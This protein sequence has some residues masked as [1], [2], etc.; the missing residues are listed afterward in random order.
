MDNLWERIPA[1]LRIKQQLIDDIKSGQRAVHSKLPPEEEMCRTFQV[2]RGT[3]RQALSEL[4]NEGYIYKIH[5][6]GTYVKSHNYEHVIHTSRF[7]S[8][9]DDLIEKGVQP[10]MEV[11]GV[12]RVRPDETVASFLGVSSREESVFAVRRRRTVEDQVIMCSVN[13]VPCSV[14]PEML[15]D[16]NDYISVHGMLKVRCDIQVCKGTRLMQ[17]MGAPEEIAKMLGVAVNSP[18]MFV[19]QIAYDEENRCVD[20][21]YIWLRSEYFRFTV[22]M[23]K[24]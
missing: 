10:R 18:V 1:Y 21:A 2:S 5:G 13:H 7:V 23:R 24:R 8:F 16:D 6:K 22:D 12:E 20:C 19:Q 11:L 17:A 3:V 14:Y 9:L 15:E 4:A